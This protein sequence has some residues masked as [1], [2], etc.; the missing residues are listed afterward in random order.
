M[1][2]K[3]II[4]SYINNFKR[5]FSQYLKPDIAISSSAYPAEGEGAVLEFLLG[6]GA[7]LDRYQETVEGTV[8]DALRH[9]KQQMVGG[10]LA[11]IRFRGTNISLESRKLVLIKGEDAPSEWSDKAAL[12]DVERIVSRKVGEAK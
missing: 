5:H 8:N 10:N 11:G 12:R 2:D 1:K 4:Q 6:E 9:V 3:K 7:T